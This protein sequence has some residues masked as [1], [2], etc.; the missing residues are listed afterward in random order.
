MDCRALTNLIQE[1]EVEVES[2]MLSTIP[3]E[4]QNDGRL[5][6]FCCCVVVVV[7]PDHMGW[8]VTMWHF[9]VDGVTEYTGERF[10]CTWET[11]IAVIL[12]STDSLPTLPSEYS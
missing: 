11:R 2:S 8:I 12:R 9:G 4:K 6:L 7:V 1:V 3:I 5:L 10:S